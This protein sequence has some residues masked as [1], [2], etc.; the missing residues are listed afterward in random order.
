MFIH[1]TRDLKIAL[2][3]PQ[4]FK[5]FKL[6]IEAPRDQ[7]GKLESALAPVATL[8]ADG[9]AWVKETWLRQQESS[10]QWQEGLAAMIGVAKKYGW[11][12][13]QQQTIRAHIEW[14]NEAPKA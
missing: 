9:H 2:M 3:E 8:T 10:P 13:E 12:D 4:D 6:V 1:V 5:K 14:P 11:V 7:S